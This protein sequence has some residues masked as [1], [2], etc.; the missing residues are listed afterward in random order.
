MVDTVTENRDIDWRTRTWLEGFE[1]AVKQA[2]AHLI[3]YGGDGNG[4]IS[5]QVVFDILN[6]L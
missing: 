4:N 5:L 3:A 2:K 1:A 6:D